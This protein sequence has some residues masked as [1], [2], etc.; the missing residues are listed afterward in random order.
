M[1]ELFHFSCV[2]RCVTDCYFI[3]NVLYLP[4]ASSIAIYHQVSRAKYVLKSIGYTQM[5]GLPVVKAF[6]MADVCHL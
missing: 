5:C 6:K 2:C 3:V 4:F 1:G